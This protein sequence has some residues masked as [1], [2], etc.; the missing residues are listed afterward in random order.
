VVIASPGLAWSLRANVA[1]F[2]MSIAFTGQR[3][4]HLPADVPRERFAFNPDYTQ[5]RFVVVDNLWR[6]WAVF[7]VPGVPQMLERVQTWPLMFQSGEIEVYCNPAQPG[8]RT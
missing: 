3:T 1:D 8:C 6:N 4:P 2:Q 7:T 5:A